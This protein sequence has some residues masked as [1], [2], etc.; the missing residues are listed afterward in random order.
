MSYPL[1]R[2][3]KTAPHPHT[4]TGMHSFLGFTDY[5]QHWIHNYTAVDTVFHAAQ[6]NSAPYPLQWTE[7]MTAALRDLKAALTSAP[8]LGLTDY[9]LPFHRYVYEMDSFTLG[10]LYPKHG[11]HHCPMDLLF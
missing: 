7:H 8:A 10:I 9:K 1:A 11:S 3:S 4:K 5:C 2:Q 6:L